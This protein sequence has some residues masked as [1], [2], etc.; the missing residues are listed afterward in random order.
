MT[1]LA[2]DP[3]RVEEL[4]RHTRRAVDDLA[5]IR[6]DDPAAVEA[7]RIVRLAQLHLETE[8][9]PCSSGSAPAR[10]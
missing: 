6:C 5:E 9:M 10:R 4:W 1:R 2:Y 8:W 7:M 3:E